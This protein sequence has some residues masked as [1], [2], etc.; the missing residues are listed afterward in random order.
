MSSKAKGR[1]P[2]RPSGPDE[3]EVGYAKPPRHSQ[4]KPG[5]SGNPK[6]RRKGSRN[7]PSTVNKVLGRKIPVVER[8]RR[9]SVPAD[10]AILHR[11][12]EMALKGD[13]K[14]GAYL[15]AQLERFQPHEPEEVKQEALSEE[16]KAI[17]ANLIGRKTK[18]R[19]RKP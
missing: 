2:R 1:G 15:L 11:Y 3:Y 12:L 18:G 10:E 6:G 14:A 13:V 5:Q 16:D 17:V 19:T 8:G 4:F 7:L 9:K